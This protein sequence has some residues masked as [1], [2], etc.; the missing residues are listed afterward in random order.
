MKRKFITV[1][2]TRLEMYL[3]RDALDFYRVHG[4]NLEK[5]LMEMLSDIFDNSMIERNEEEEI[6]KL[7]TRNEEND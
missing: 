4:D 5:T 7:F 6:E 3:I 2:F 1:E